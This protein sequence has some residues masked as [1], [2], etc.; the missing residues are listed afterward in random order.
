MLH[1]GREILWELSDE[2]GHIEVGIDSVGKCEVVGLCEDLDAVRECS[3]TADTLLE[4]GTRCTPA[5]DLSIE[6]RFNYQLG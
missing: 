2:A 5:V 4:G 1:H 6:Q 3:L